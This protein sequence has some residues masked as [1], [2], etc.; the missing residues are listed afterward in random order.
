MKNLVEYLDQENLN[1]KDIYIIFPHE[2]HKACD[3]IAH[4]I[5]K[6]LKV[7]CFSIKYRALNRSHVKQISGFLKQGCVLVIGY[8]GSMIDENYYKL[9]IANAF[10]RQVILVDLNASNVP[11]YIPEYINYQ[12][13]IKRKDES[14]E[15]YM[16]LEHAIA[17]VLS[18]DIKAMLYE[19][20]MQKCE[21]IE[22][23]TGKTIK[24]VDEETFFSRLQD[25]LTEEHT[26][27]DEDI[28]YS[29]YLDDDDEALAKLLDLI[30][31]DRIEVLDALNPDLKK[32]NE[33]G[34]NKQNTYISGDY[35]VYQYGPG[36]NVAGDSIQGDKHS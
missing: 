35:N 25:Q 19:K 23:K 18:G 4:Q 8:E 28:L 27:F 24:K 34:K 22:G 11:I 10:D 30:S 36:D 21:L 13:H 15:Y 16:R 29:L 9:G 5:C 2:W 3:F 12:F 6:K 31:Q 17:Q 7:R 1:P 32:L 33:T 14:S 26:S 20:V